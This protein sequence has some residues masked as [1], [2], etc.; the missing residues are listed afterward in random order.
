METKPTKWTNPYLYL[1]PTGIITFLLGQ[2][3]NYDDYVKGPMTM[4]LSENHS[5]FNTNIQFLCDYSNRL[6][7][8]YLFDCCLPLCLAWAFYYFSIKQVDDKEDHLALKIGLGIFVS[9]A[10]ADFIENF[11]A[12]YWYAASFK[13]FDEFTRHHA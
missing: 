13:N 8:Y 4:L 1:F 11:Y 7:F 2:S 9:Y 12:V 3:L 10:I 6:D 5:T